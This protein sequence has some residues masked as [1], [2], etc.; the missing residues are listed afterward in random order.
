MLDRP[1]FL[2]ATC[3]VG[4]QQAVKAEVAHRWPDFSLA[5]WRPG[6]LTF[7]LPE[8]HRLPADFE[9][10]A[11]F[12]RASGFS[13]GPV[14]GEDLQTLARGVWTLFGPRSW[15]R[16]HVWERDAARPGE[17]G[18]EPGLTPAAAAAYEA[19]LR[20]CPHGGAAAALADAGQRPARPGQTVLDCILLDP[21][22]W[23]VGTHR[24]R[25]V[26]SQWP[27]GL[28]PLALPPGAISRA[29]L[30]MAEALR[31][32]ELPIPPQARWAE[33]GSAPGGSCQA[34]LQHGYHV[35]G[36]DPAAMDPRILGHPRFTHLRRRSAAVRRRE[37]RKVRWLAADMNVP[38]AY[39]LDAVQSIVTHAEVHIR[40]MLLTLKLPQWKLAQ[41]VPAYLDRV[42][43][44]GYNVVRARQLQHH[45]REF[46]VA[47]LQQPF[48]R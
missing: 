36:I 45:R 43:S 4:G 24:V 9:L 19:L 2:F 17:H 13:L 3:Q 28:S 32:A 14:R 34:L 44:W 11:V 1:G 46:C 31:W 42:R 25:S 12:A 33:I 35:L 7:K 15:Q 41:E 6:F 22:Q 39:T 37:F 27:G 16:I 10:Q 26:A 20:T 5:F 38:P 40:G 21:G 30:K 48:R 8:G 18:Y 23:W 47:A 29:W